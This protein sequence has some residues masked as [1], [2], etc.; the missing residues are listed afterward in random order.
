MDP[1]VLS[2]EV[3]VR[4]DGIELIALSDAR[5]LRPRSWI[6]SRRGESR[7]PPTERP[8]FSPRQGP[9]LVIAA[10]ESRIVALP[11]VNPRYR[12]L[13]SAVRVGL[14]RG[15]AYVLG[16]DRSPTERTG[17]GLLFG[18]LV[19]VIADEGMMP[20][21]DSRADRETSH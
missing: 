12:P 2:E 8:R 3:P 10:D 4:A 20:A 18:S 1:A 13:R 15:I 6:P 17:Y 5:R 9:R 11:A 19:W 21:L 14:V 16:G 7:P